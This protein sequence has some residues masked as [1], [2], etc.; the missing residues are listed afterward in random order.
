MVSEKRVPHNLP[1]AEEY[2]LKKQIHS[3]VIA[4]SVCLVERFPSEEF[5]GVD[6]VQERLGGYCMGWLSRIAFSVDRY[7]DQNS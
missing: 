6:L 1:F 5:K 7:R 2:N 4:S 3:I